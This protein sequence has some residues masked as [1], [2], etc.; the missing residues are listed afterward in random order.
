MRFCLFL[1]AAALGISQPNI[2]EPKNTVDLNALVLKSLGIDHASVVDA[3]QN[4]SSWAV[5]MTPGVATT[6][7]IVVVG[8]DSSANAFLV[9]GR[10][11]KATIDADRNIH[12]QYLSKPAR[13]VVTDRS[14]R[15]LKRE[16]VAQG[17]ISTQ[18][19]SYGPNFSK[20]PTPFYDDRVAQEARAHRQNFANP[21]DVA[22]AYRAFHLPVPSNPQ[23]S[24]ASPAN[25]GL[26]CASLSQI[27]DTGDGYLAFFEPS[28]GALKETLRAKLPGRLL[29][30]IG[31]FGDRLLMVDAARGIAIV[32]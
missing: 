13:A 26:V 3:I 23:L 27:P 8:D 7:T 18:P 24:W 4:H 20:I 19:V 10:F 14:G 2:L 30:T 17:P 32:Y 1:F 12:L 31:G 25:N 15:I 11:G 28:T 21:Y 9:D 22:A 6:Q 5:L 16:S 29:P